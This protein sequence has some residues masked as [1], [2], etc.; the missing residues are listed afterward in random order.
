[1]ETQLSRDQR[2]YVRSVNDSAELMV[3][4][5]NDVLDISRLE[6]GRMSFEKITVDLYYLCQSLTHNIQQQATAKHVSL[7]CDFDSSAPRYVVSDP[8]RIHQL[9]L[10]LVSNAIKFTREHGRVVL[11]VFASH[12]PPEFWHRKAL[13]ESDSAQMAS[14]VTDSAS[15]DQYMTVV[16]VGIPII[17][18][19][20]IAADD[21][22]DEA[23]NEAEESRSDSDSDS[24]DQ[25]DETRMSVQRTSRPARLRHY[26]YTY[27]Q[28]IDNGIGISAETLPHL[29]SPYTQAKLSTVRKHGGTGL[30]LSIVQQIIKNMGGHI[31]VSSVVN[32]GSVFTFVLR[33]PISHQDEVDALV[34]ANKVDADTPRHPTL[35]QTP[36]PKDGS[37]AASER[38]SAETSPVAQNG[39][40]VLVTDDSDVNRKILQRILESLGYRVLQ[41]GDGAEALRII[42]SKTAHLVCVFM[43]ISMPV[44][45]GYEATRRYALQAS[46][47]QSSHSPRTH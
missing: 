21:H 5:V 12:K 15:H 13:A 32:R 28:V 9:L 30:G 23:V 22:A 47:C 6:A 37:P 26:V 11:S 4:I 19:D 45:D 29:F 43:D 38:L 3:N 36:S 7:M 2:E 20:V 40:T 31:S 39:L 33:F 24:E 14:L 35:Q 41:A 8:T 18:E 1:M 42:T 25:S 10:N 46:P 44:M 34:A 27:F 17:R 16:D